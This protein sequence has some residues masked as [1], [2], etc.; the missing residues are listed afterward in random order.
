MAVHQGSSRITST[1]DGKILQGLQIYR[2]FYRDYTGL[3]RI[4]QGIRNSTGILQGLHRLTEFY[5]DYSTGTTHSLQRILQGLH[6]VYRGFYRDYTGLQ[7]ILQGLHMSAEDSAGTTDLQGLHVCSGFYRDNTDLQGFY[8]GYT[9]P[10][11]STGTT[12]VYRNDIQGSTRQQEDLQNN[13]SLQGFYM[14][15][16]TDIPHQGFHVKT[17]RFYREAPRIYQTTPRVYSRDLLVPIF[18]CE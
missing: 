12:Q 6:I 17:C 10:Q 15:R 16:S 8:K 14:E 18:Y 13:R 3:Q 9:G 11:V 4:L 1:R 2:G 7:R 5:R